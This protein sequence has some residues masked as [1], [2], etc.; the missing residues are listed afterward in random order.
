MRADLVAA[1]GASTAPIVSVIAA[2]GYGKSTL[3]A[4]FVDHDPRP[5]AWL[6]LGEDADDPV[7]L[8]RYLALAI[9]PVA[10][11]G[12]SLT[13]ELD[14]LQP[15]IR[16]V[17]AGL[18]AAIRGADAPFI[19][20]VDDVHLLTDRRCF[21]LLRNLSGEV[22]PG[23]LVVFVA[24]SETPLAL[25]RARAAGELL[26]LGI[27][28]L[29]F[30]PDDAAD[31][32]RASG[33][34][35]IDAED[36]ARLTDQTEG[37]AVGLYLAARSIAANPSAAPSF[38][39]DDR[40]VADYLRETMLADLAPEEVDF[41]VRSS[42]LDELS[43]ELCDATLATTG[44][45]AM[46]ETLEASNLLVVPLD[47]RRERFRY[48]HLFRDLLRMELEH[49]SP[50]L[51]P[52]LTARA[53][54]WCEGQN[55]TDQA[56]AYAIAGHDVDRVGALIERY[57]QATYYGGRANVVRA[58]IEWFGDHGD[59]R[60]HPG[61][62]LLGAWLHAAEQHPVEAERWIDAVPPSDGIDAADREREAA[63]ALLHATMGRDGVERMRVDAER[64]SS[65][66][67]AAS[68]WRP[69]A[70]LVTGLASLCSGDLESASRAFQHAVEFASQ[71]GIAI[72]WALAHAELTIVGL[73]IGDV[74]SAAAH[75]SA[76]RRIVEEGRLQGYPT[77]ALTYAVGARVALVQGDPVRARAC[78]E[79]AASLDPGLTY[80]M[81]VF[82]LQTDL[83]LARSAMGLGDTASAEGFLSRADD[84]IAHRPHL[85]TL[86]S[87]L[88]SARDELDALR[89]SAV[90]APTL[91]PAEARLLPLLT[92]HLSFRE[93]GGELFVSSHTVKTQAI[94]IYRKL[95]VS[96]RGEAVRVAREIGLLTP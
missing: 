64:V 48:H 46:L 5:S 20:V 13:N 88:E 12:E 1:V 37:W 71:M 19:L 14:G 2:S 86:V 47:H 61:V 52:V 45:G 55:L 59:L 27:D 65:L 44:S 69:N 43:G 60:R 6:S 92:T 82:A 56:V 40:Y 85:D 25:G 38:S 28:D 3:M 95:G 24:R 89:A 32:L 94:S 83:L 49:R 53:S 84:V 91:T 78:A 87:E 63:R 68:P 93:I 34:R 72:P 33:A 31:L 21:A 9:D 57:A 67:P 81:P 66:L 42:V 51:V 76:A 41:L 8:A 17:T 18:A 16:L 80:V 26:E 62:A 36:V 77:S 39:G 35:E 7:A 79:E 75:A 54:V 4:Q 10:P 29:R 11:V 74:L 58:W 70:W 22:A 30:T 90:G 15:R 96:S 23:C 73:E 50:E